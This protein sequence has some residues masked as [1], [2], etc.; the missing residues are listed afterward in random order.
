M[1]DRWVGGEG[2]QQGTRRCRHK[3]HATGAPINARAHKARKDLA[4]A[5]QIKCNN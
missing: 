5:D 4:R 3:T 2:A 1:D